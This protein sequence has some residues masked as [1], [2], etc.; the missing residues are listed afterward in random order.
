MNQLNPEGDV[1]SLLSKLLV[2]CFNLKPV[3]TDFSTL[4]LL[5]TNLF[6]FLYS[7]PFAVV[8][9]DHIQLIVH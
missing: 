1:L 5:K 6:F 8:T 4:K 2:F 3:L 9:I 7:N